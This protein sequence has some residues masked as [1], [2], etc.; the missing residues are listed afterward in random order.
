MAADFNKPVTTDPYADCLAELRD[1]DT[2]LAVMLDPAVV[3]PANVPTSGI[4]WTS[5]D[6][7][8]QKYNGT[9]WGDLSALYAINISGNAGSAT[10]AAACSGNAATATTAAAC[11]GNAATA[12]S[13]AACS[14]NAATA[15][16]A[17]GLK[18][19]TT[20]V[21]VNGA[22][23]P[24]AG[25]VLTALS[26]TAAAWA[27]PSGFPTGTA[28]LF[29]QTAAPTG[30]TKSTT[31]NDKALRVVSGTVGSGGTVAFSTAFASKGVAGTVGG[32]TLS[33]AQSG[34]PAHTHTLQWPTTF[35][36]SAVMG[37]LDGTNTAT[38][39]SGSGYAGVPSAT[40]TLTAPYYAANASSA[41]GAASS[42]THSFTGTAID[43]AVQYVDVIIATKDA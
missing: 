3:T 10:T 23:A 42:H 2:A 39:A 16:A 18:S 14:G 21:V 40:A 43:L 6:N 41:E 1:N 29:A 8:W 33:S 24:S 12:T 38:F 37:V 17:D 19:A 27:A 9:S 15:T 22:T 26:S 30:W 20:T 35:V 32:T 13:A 31:H 36:G 28:M 25:Q 5:A 4:R 34:T 11:S 7:K